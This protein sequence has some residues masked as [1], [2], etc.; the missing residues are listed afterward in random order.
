MH[1]G[2]F[3]VLRNKTLVK[4]ASSALTNFDIC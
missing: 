3:Q 4:D 2:E 1:K